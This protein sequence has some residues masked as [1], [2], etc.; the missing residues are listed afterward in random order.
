VQVCG[1]YFT[2]GFPNQNCK[3]AAGKPYI[4]G[5]GIKK[6]EEVFEGMIIK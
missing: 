3:L 1:D 4:L 2:F 6:G 5:Q